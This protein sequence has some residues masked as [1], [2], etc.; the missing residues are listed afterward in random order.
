MDIL[1]LLMSGKFGF[2]CFSSSGDGYS[3]LTFYCSPVGDEILVSFSNR[4]KFRSQSPVHDIHDVIFF[5]EAT[6]LARNQWQN[7]PLV[8]CYFATSS[9]CFGCFRIKDYVMNIMNR[10]DIKER[11][12]PLPMSFFQTVTVNIIYSSFSLVN[13]KSYD[14]NC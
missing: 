12:S 14:K 1:L 10:R 5:T 9:G 11:S 6:E 2:Y 4:M 13:M 3:V 7:L 8:F